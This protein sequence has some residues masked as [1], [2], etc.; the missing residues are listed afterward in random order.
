[1]KVRIIEDG[2]TA[3]GFI[4]RKGRGGHRHFVFTPTKHRGKISSIFTFTSHGK[5]GKDIGDLLVWRMARELKL[6]KKQFQDLINCPLSQD[7]YEQLLAS[8]L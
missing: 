7:D 8:M 1:M 5:R 6:S 4:Q 2:L 3:K